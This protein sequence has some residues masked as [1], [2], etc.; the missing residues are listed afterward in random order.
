MKINEFCKQRKINKLNL[1]TPLLVPSFSSKGF[2]DVD[3]FFRNLNPYISEIKLISAY[4]IGTNYINS[5]SIYDSDVVIIDSGG[6]ESNGNFDLSEQYRKSSFI[7]ANWDINQYQRVIKDIRDYTKIIL[8]SFDNYATIKEQI[9]AT[10]VFFE[11]SSF[12]SDFLVKPN[13]PN[14]KVINTSDY[15]LNISD[16]S[17]FDI[18][19]FT[20]KELGNN[21]I[22][23]IKNLI[24]IRQ[25]LSQKGLDLPIHIFGCLDPISIWLYYLCGADI[26][27]GLSWL[28]YHYDKTGIASYIFN[29]SL[30]IDPSLNPYETIISNAYQ[31]LKTLQILKKQLIQFSVNYSI[32]DIGLNS[33]ITSN[34]FNFLRRQELEV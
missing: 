32:T 14:E 20:E 31:N 12:C 21:Y 16:V 29:T 3:L 4:D 22:E 1:K 30:F 5:D 7:T 28:R 23:R 25:I 26:F 24:T 15:L 17:D 13:T 27:D 2:T 34:I 11:N 19:G 18:L 10:K 9:T 6:Y 33:C 8:V